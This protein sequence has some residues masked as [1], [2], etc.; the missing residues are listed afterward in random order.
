VNFS[1]TGQ[2]HH[3]SQKRKYSAILFVKNTILTKVR[4]LF[5]HLAAK[6]ETMKK[7]LRLLAALTALL[8]PLS[9]QD[10]FH[11]EQTGTLLVRLPELYPPSTRAANDLPDVGSFSVSVVNASGTT[12]YENDYAHFPEELPL[13][14]GT[15]TVS[16]ESE[17]FD[18]PAFDTPQWG[19]T[20][21]V[22]VA[23][24]NSVSVTLDCRQ[25]NSGLRLE[26]D[27]SFRSAFPDGTLTLKGPGGTLPYAYGETR[28]AFFLPG[29]VSL[30]LDDGGYVQTLFS[31]TLEACQMLSLR[32]CANAGT[33]SGGISIQ[34]DTTRTWLTERFVV[35]GGDPGEIDGAYDVSEARLHPGETGVW[36]QGYIVG[37]ATNTKKVAFEPPFNKRTNLVLGTRASTNDIDYCLSV[38][39]RA[40]EIREAL[41]LQDNPDLLG[42][43]IY[44]RGDLVSAYYGI[45]GLKAPSEFQFN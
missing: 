41:N 16:A 2:P 45:P 32:L 39:L 31:R 21:I 5:P 8:L 4:P 30:L 34:L 12:V 13:P 17:A 44:I 20:Q 24:G 36:V 38:E 22:T 25:C 15:Y 37:V 27:G 6:K 10:F 3:A 26:V 28:T 11:Q 43:K 33:R 14:A 7:L 18:A 42:T 1:F 40:G 9:C 35:G 29:T 23:E 19:D